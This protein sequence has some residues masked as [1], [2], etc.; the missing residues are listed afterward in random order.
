[1][2]TRLNDGRSL[3]DSKA[4]QAAI[5]AQGI[6]QNK[7][8]LDEGHRWLKLALGTAMAG[9]L[10]FTCAEFVILCSLAAENGFSI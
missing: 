2:D 7:R 4:G 5:Y 3:H 10:I 1:M 6:V 9:T 8:C